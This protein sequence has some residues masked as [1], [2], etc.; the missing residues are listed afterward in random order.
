MVKFCL[1]NFKIKI[2]ILNNCLKVRKYKQ[3]TSQTG[4]N[5]KST[6]YKIVKV[7]L[8][9]LDRRLITELAH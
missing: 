4:P 5:R 9:I 8:Y 6:P 7:G 3:L 2:F 1:I